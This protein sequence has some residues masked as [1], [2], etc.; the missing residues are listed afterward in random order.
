MMVAVMDGWME[1]WYGTVPAVVKVCVKVWPLPI[2]AEVN[3]LSSAVTVCCVE[4]SNFQVTV[5]PTGTVR[6]IGVNMKLLI[7]TVEPP[8][9]AAEPLVVAEPLVAGGAAV[10]DGLAPPLSEPPQPV[11]RASSASTA[12]RTKSGR[13]EDFMSASFSGN[14]RL[15]GTLRRRYP[16][17]N[18]W[19][20]SRCR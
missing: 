9:G 13:P 4:S 12:T 16:V 6:L 18:A 14:T 1:Q 8:L 7:S 5:A 11:A 3:E 19:V 10:A 20:L 15:F 17:G 2:G